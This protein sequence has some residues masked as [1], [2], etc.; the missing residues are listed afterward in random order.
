MIRRISPAVLALLQPPADAASAVDYPAYRGVSTIP[1][2]TSSDGSGQ[3]LFFPKPF[4]REQVEVIQRL[5]TRPGVVVQGPPGTGKTHT[6]A[7]IISHYL[8]QGKRVLVTSQKAPPL[9]VL[10]EKLPEAVRPLAVSLVES[11]RDGLRQFQESVDIIADRLHRTRPA[12]VAREIAALDTRIEG[13]HRG[14][15]AIDRQVEEIGRGSMTAA[16]L[17]GERVE[18]VDAARRLVAGADLATWLPDDID[19]IPSHDAEFDDATVIRLRSARKA[20]GDRLGSLHHAPP[21]DTLPDAHALVTLHGDLVEVQRIQAATSGSEALAPDAAI[22]AVSA[23]R[24]QASD[25][26]ASLYGPDASPFAWSRDLLHC[27]RSDDD[28]PVLAALA[29]LE[30]Q[31]AAVAGKRAISSSGRWSCRKGSWLIPLSAKQSAGWREAKNWASSRICSPGSSRLRSPVCAYP[32]GL[33]RARRNGPKSNAIA[34]RS[35]LPSGWLRPG[36]TSV[37]RPGSIR[38]RVKV[39][40]SRKPCVGNWTT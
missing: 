40:L 35:I 7:N 9:K 37:C 19:V 14:L 30:P 22:E 16:T 24:Q 15:A 8:A 4:N 33:H 20:A 29:G 28:D 1:G 6:I 34:P 11:D 13:L 25:L 21:P 10:R 38:R 17:D 31:V 5:A 36:T 18:P 26:K 3:D 32:A 23:L 2:V 39:P 27:W 12:E